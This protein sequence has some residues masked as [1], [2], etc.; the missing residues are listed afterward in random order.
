MCRKRGKKR[1]QITK[2][3]RAPPKID[4][5][6]S[7]GIGATKSL[8]R[9]T[10][11]RNI[12]RPFRGRMPRSRME[13]TVSALPAAKRKVHIEIPNYLTL[14]IFFSKVTLFIFSHG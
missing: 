5:I 3:R 13:R 6:K 7:I 14:K 11:P 1:L 2:C 12:L 4:R 8:Q 9:G 10:K